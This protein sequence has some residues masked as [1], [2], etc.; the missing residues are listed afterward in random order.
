VVQIQGGSEAHTLKARR[1]SLEFCDKHLI[2]TRMNF[3]KFW[4]LGEHEGFSCWRWSFQSLAEAQTA[5]NEA[6]KHLVARFRSGSYPTKH[7]YYP[8]RPFREEILQEM[9]DAKGVSAV[10][11]RNS[12]GCQ[13]LNT[14]RVMFV[15]IDLPEP[16]KKRA[17]L[18]QMLFGKPTPPPS[19]DPGPENEALARVES[20]TRNNYQWGWRVYRTRAGLR[21]LATHATIE[22]DAKTAEDIF[23]ALG[24][25]PLYRKLCKAQKCYRARLTPKPWRC[26]FSG[27]KPPRWPFQNVRAE[28]RFAQWQEKYQA[29]ATEWATCKLIR[30]IGNE[31][32]HPDV[33]PIV[34][35][36]D[37]TTRVSS[38][39][40][41]A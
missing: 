1:F 19:P 15:D 24:A 26:E 14:A 10:V 40:Q 22:A 17:G 41:L 38:N 11:T 32:V 5:A 7:G 28:K 29:A 31:M 30:Q 18:F 37:E 23:Q 33:Q 16:P 25:D 36:H 6:A 12:Y 9:K 13:V 20:W 27:G 39:L 4:A 8:D 35:L 34:K 21:L 3:P 2:L